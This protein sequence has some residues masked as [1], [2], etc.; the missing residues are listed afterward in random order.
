MPDDLIVATSSAALGGT[1]TDNGSTY[2][3]AALNEVW[4]P[5]SQGRK[6]L[7]ADTLALLATESPPFGVLS[8]DQSGSLLWMES[9]TGTGTGWVISPDTA[10]IITT[11]SLIS[12][13]PTIA[14]GSLYDFSVASNNNVTVRRRVLSTGESLDPAQTEALGTAFFN[15]RRVNDG[16]IVGIKPGTQTGQNSDIRFRTLS[17][18]SMSLS[19]DVLVGTDNGAGTT[20]LEP[21]IYVPS[22]G[23]AYGIRRAV[24]EL[25]LF[26]PI[27]GAHSVVSDPLFISDGQAVVVHVPVLRSVVCLVNKISPAD[28]IEVVVCNEATG[29]IRYSQRIDPVSSVNRRI[30]AG[31]LARTTASVNGASIFYMSGTRIVRLDLPQFA[32]DPVPL[33]RLVYDIARRAGVPA[34]RIDV[35][36]LQGEL[37]GYGIGRTTSAR[38]QIELLQQYGF[39][40]AV[41]RGSLLF[42]NRERVPDGTI[43]GD[44]LSAHVVGEERPTQ[45]RR[46]RIED[47]EL[48]REV[49]IQYSDF[50]TDYEPGVQIYERRLTDTE[51]VA[52]IDLTAISMTADQAA[53]IAEISMLEAIV[54]RE[55]VDF[56]LVA[57]DANKALI[58]SDIKTLEVG[59]QQTVVRLIQE[60]YAWPGVQSWQARRHDPAIYASEARGVS[61]QLPRN[62]SVIPGPTTLELLD[63][64][65]VRL[66]DDVSGYFAAMGG[67][68]T[69]PGVLLGWPGGDLFRQEPTG[70][71]DIARLTRPGSSFG[72]A[73]NALPGAPYTVRT[74]DVLD[75][76]IESG[77]PAGSTFEGMLLGG[78]LAALEVRQGG[79]RIGWEILQYQ[80]SDF[81]ET[82]NRYELSGLLRGRFG[83]EWAIGLHDVGDR[84]V[85]L[86]QVAQILTESDELDVERAHRAATIGADPAGS[87]SVDFAWSGVDRIP[88]SPVHLRA[89]R[90]GDITFSWTRRDRVGTELVSG[91]T[92][93]LSEDAEAYE[94][95]IYDGAS[96]VRTLQ[97]S[98]TEAVY[99]D[100]TTDFGSAQD[101]I[102]IAV[103]QMG[104]LGRGYPARALITVE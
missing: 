47:Y 1:V 90:D 93:P 53:Q 36:A 30:N 98:T 32:C 97:V 45:A 63:A 19:L 34:S 64:P 41:D 100:E 10:A 57:T 28:A 54:A 15:P 92:L 82:T 67:T 96:V 55:S 60:D 86:P 95:D 27:T 4:G 56:S 11:Q 87:P 88:Y 69:I 50:A 18:P 68:P 91:Q 26:N 48:P 79:D 75:V 22:T 14:G 21:I 9:G 99:T 42:R 6:R 33:D 65:L 76:T 43:G 58:P 12:R 84:F 59:G 80:T 73:A 31:N 29:A 40:D 24:G 72:T 51:G 3:S 2:Y 39:F 13:F 8:W 102:E 74:W 66:G 17:V 49:R 46:T 77:L 61:T 5:T 89:V 7:N 25:H 23:L 44:D 101:E 71:E 104:E 16:L 94:V 52:D 83:T 38:Q 103:Y 20:R 37:L 35:S 78:G 62:P 70:L 85:T 81:N